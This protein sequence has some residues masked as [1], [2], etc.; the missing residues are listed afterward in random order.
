MDTDTHILPLMQRN[1]MRSGMNSLESNREHFTVVFA[2]MD[3]APSSTWNP[4]REER[5]GQAG[6]RCLCPRI[7]RIRHKLIACKLTAKDV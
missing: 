2:V 3:G 5:P 4:A 7:Q 1:A 6:P